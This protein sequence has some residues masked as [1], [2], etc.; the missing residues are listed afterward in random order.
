MCIRDR[1]KDALIRY[2]SN[3]SDNWFNTI[4]LHLAFQ[5]LQE[6]E[7]HPAGQFE[8]VVDKIID[9]ALKYREESVNQSL[10]RLLHRPL[11]RD[12]EKNK[13][14]KDKD[15]FL[16]RLDGYLHDMKLH[17]DQV[18]LE[19]I[20]LSTAG[21][22]FAKGI[23]PVISFTFDTYSEID[24]RIRLSG[25]LYRMILR[26]RRKRGKILTDLIPGH[27]VALKRE[28]FAILGLA[29]PLKPIP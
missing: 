21:G 15:P 5:N 17:R 23:L 4:A 7:L 26:D 6:L 12:I 19:Y 2:V 11:S 22:I 20:H 3:P 27:V 18:D 25:A 16:T 10:Y 8:R 13:S 9:L 29:S 14:S 28:D 1:L 24:S